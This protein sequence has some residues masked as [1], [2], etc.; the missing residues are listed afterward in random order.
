MAQSHRSRAHVS[1]RAAALARL[2]PARAGEAWAPS[3]NHPTLAA[4]GIPSG[5][6]CQP[7]RAA[8]AAEASAPA[9]LLGGENCPRSASHGPG[10]ATR[11]SNV[12]RL[13]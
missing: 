5:H 7:I 3:S 11:Q 2:A 9:C 4:G 10:G 13:S 6:S 1:G 12:R 8:A